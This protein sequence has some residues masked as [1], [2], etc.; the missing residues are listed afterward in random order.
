MYVDIVEACNERLKIGMRRLADIN[1]KEQ[2]S[3]SIRFDSLDDG[4]VAIIPKKFS[5]P[6]NESESIATI[7]GNISRVKVTYKSSNEKVAVVSSA[8]TVTG[9]SNGAA[10]I[11]T[12]V[13][14]SNGTTQSF[15]T[16][17]TIE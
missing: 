8:G 7:A 11:T 14:L 17:V 4:I 12:T 9:K 3:G 1:G 6:I 2:K 15:A 13:S 16:A 5:I 10:T